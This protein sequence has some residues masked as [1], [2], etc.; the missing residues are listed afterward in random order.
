[1]PDI[2]RLK[3]GLLYVVSTHMRI[4]SLPKSNVVMT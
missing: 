1:M 4:E 3:E 2:D